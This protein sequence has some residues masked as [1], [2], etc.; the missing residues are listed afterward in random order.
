MFSCLLQLP[1]LLRTSLIAKAMDSIAKPLN[2][3]AN[4]T[5]S[6]AKPAN[7]IANGMN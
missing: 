4:G 6:V 1:F 7:S 5:N 2:S 3:L